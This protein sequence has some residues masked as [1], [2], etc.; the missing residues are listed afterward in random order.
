MDIIS[1][2]KRITIHYKYIHRLITVSITNCYSL[3]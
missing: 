2:L 1:P 3:L